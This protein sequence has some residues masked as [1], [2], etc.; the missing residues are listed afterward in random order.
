MCTCISLIF[1]LWKDEK[2]VFSLAFETRP[3]N[4]KEEEEEK[5]EKENEEKEKEDNERGNG[6]NSDPNQNVALPVAA[7]LG[8][9][10]GFGI[11][12]FIIW[13][14]YVVGNTAQVAPKP[15]LSITWQSWV[16]PDV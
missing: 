9:V 6:N 15:E 13:K 8:A 7:T 1:S 16:Q 12:S 11:V 3:N 10:S 5:E 14:K 2:F 4:K